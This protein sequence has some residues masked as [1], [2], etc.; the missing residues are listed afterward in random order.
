MGLLGLWSPITLRADLRSQCGL[1][2][3]CRSRRDLF[4]G[5]SHVLCSQVF[6]VDSRLLVVGS[7]NWQTSENSTPDP[8]FGHNLCF[9]CPNEQWEHILDIYASRAFQWYK[10][11][12]KTL[13]FDPCNG[14]LKF[15]EST[16]TPSP[17]VGV[18]LGVWVF[19]PLHSL[20]LSYTP[21]LSLILVPGLALAL[22]LGLPLALAPELPLGPQ[23]YNPFVFGPGPKAKVA[24][25]WHCKFPVVCLLYSWPLSRLYRL[26]S[27]KLTS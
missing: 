19:T 4:N 9:R 26:C 15:W 18:A 10:K 8:S 12:H 27:I 17:K 7:Q 13:R 24:T 6:R 11:C 20:T 3:S 5:M 14:S 25:S 22:A 1:K 16:G 2:Q 23:P 21:G